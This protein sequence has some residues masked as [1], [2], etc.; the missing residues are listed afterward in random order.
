VTTSNFTKFINI[1]G[2]KICYDEVGPENGAPILIMHGWGCNR[3][4]VASIRDILSSKMRVICIDLPGHGLSDE[5]HEVW[6]VYEYTNLIEKFIDALKLKNPVLL[7]HS[8]GGR[9][10]ILLSSRCNVNK[11]ILVDS[12]GIKPRRK[13]KYHLKVYSFKLFRNILP[14]IIGKKRGEKIINKWR[15]KAGSSDY[16]QASPMM[17]AILSKA[18]N[19]D[20]KAVMPNIKSPTLLIWGEEDTATPLSDAKIMEK[21]IP[22]AG[23]VSF[24]G[25]G[26]YSFLDNPF[27]F[28]TVLTNF[29]NKELQ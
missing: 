18:V 5:P 7:G 9:I 14:F 17:R 28:K 10:S 16:A 21:L 19:E 20:L 3:Q 6:G 23:L 26:H 11:V 24:K 25:C 12:A 29:L 8:F 4:T 27:G 2:L 15:K 13:L 22:D 1:L